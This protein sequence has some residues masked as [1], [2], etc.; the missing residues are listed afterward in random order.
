L[1]K[2]KKSQ[3]NNFSTLRARKMATDNN[4]VVLKIGG[5]FLLKDNQPDVLE[6]RQMAHVVRDLLN[7]SAQRRIVVVVGGGT[8]D[9]IPPHRL[10][11]LTQYSPCFQ[12]FLR[13]TTSV[14]RRHSA[15]R[16]VS[17]TIWACV[18]AQ[19]RSSS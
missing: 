6:L 3:P 2:K 1:K 5:S 12:A 19:R 16:P 8:N 10:N 11:S 18:F 15:H 4:V 14:R 7:A 9:A 13:A 17:W